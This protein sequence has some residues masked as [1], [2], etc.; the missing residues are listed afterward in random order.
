MSEP[1]AASTRPPDPWR[2]LRP[3]CAAS[4]LVAAAFSAAVAIMLV[5][6]VTAN[7]P[8]PQEDANFQSLK[9]ELS[10]RPDSG[11]VKEAIR[12]AD[13]RLRRD[14]FRRREVARKGAY[15]LTGGAAALMLALGLLVSA[16]PRP[17]RP[18]SR[19]DDETA[20]RR[21]AAVAR[22]G[23]LAAVL[24]MLGA[25]VAWGVYGGGPGAM[26]S[27]SARAPDPPAPR[28]AVA[29][30]S[31]PATML[32]GTMPGLEVIR[33]NWPR[34][35]GPLGAGVYDGPAPTR[36]DGA[37][38][39][40]ILWKRKLP[41][42][43][44]SSPIVWGGR[45]VITAADKATR[46]VLCF[47]ANTGEPLWERQIKVEGSPTSAPGVD[48]P[49]EAA[50]AN[51]GD[52]AT[53]P[54][55]DANSAEEDRPLSSAGYAAA[56]PATDGNCFCA[57]FA[58]GDIACFEWDGTERWGR[59]LS[60][61]ENTYGYSSSLDLVGGMV[62]VQNDRGAADTGMSRLLAL[63]VKSGAVL[64]EANRPVGGSWTSPIVVPLGEKPAVLALGNPWLIAHLLEDGSELWRAEVGG[65]DG[66][67]SPV[68]AGGMVLAINANTWLS[69]VR[70]GGA[71]EVTETHLAWKDGNDVPDITSP[72]SDGK[73][74]WTLTTYGVLSCREVATGAAAGSMKVRG[75]FHASPSIAGGLLYLLETDGTMVI[76]E[77]RPGGR[78]VAR[79]RLPDRTL[80]SPAFAGRRIYVRGEKYLYCIGQS[81]GR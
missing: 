21:R 20:P 7:P 15:L 16:P 65:A 43:G 30:G 19:L 22:M 70:P 17:I 57:I 76:L 45:V 26:P 64:W 68:L 61:Q 29:T 79:C 58:N 67:P 34:F 38:G 10:E 66:A 6:A 46:K 28:Q 39:A 72:V 48:E 2:I 42:G 59:N 9:A 32:A 44:Y 36:W 50:D 14:F 1:I 75:T 52:P 23:V 51:S 62:I 33:G 5:N 3:A 18:A 41:L 56:T 37:S 8:D 53:A 71:G 60:F 73:L 81:E 55:P 31:V 25:G 40:G 54:A 13:L 77:A 47:D 27:L 63:D 4:A 80:A 12:A 49:E 24:A 78:E 35:R 69:A 74:V 11:E